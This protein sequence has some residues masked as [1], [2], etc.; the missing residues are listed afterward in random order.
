MLE[1]NH[2]FNMPNILVLNCTEKEY[3]SAMRYKSLILI[4]FSLMLAGCVSPP[5]LQ[6]PISAGSQYPQQ[7]AIML[8]VTGKFANSGKAVLNGF[9]AA[10]YDYLQRSPLNVNIAVVDTAKG[11]INALYKQAVNKGAIFVVGPLT[12]SNVTKLAHENSLE[13]P[14][15]ALNTTDNYQQMHV[16]NLYQ[17]GLFYQDELK[18]VAQRAWQK[19]PGRAMIIAPANSVGRLGVKTLQA[20]WKNYG[21]VINSIVLYSNSSSMEDQI[22]HGLNIDISQSNEKQLHKI[23]RNKL[24][25]NPRR[26][27]D[28]DDVFLIAPAQQAREIRPL[29]AFY[30]AGE[31]PTYST[32]IVYTGAVSQRLDQDLN[33]VIFC[34]APWTLQDPWTLP[35]VLASLNQQVTKTWPSSYKRYS[36][37]YALGIDAFYLMLK[38]NMMA[39]APNQGFMGATGTLFL[40]KY[41]HIYRQLDWAQFRDGVPYEL[42]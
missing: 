6:T 8:P 16:T 11:N 22:K 26:R 3:Y 32:S 10:Y 39:A 25:F 40:D 33:G 15:L 21:G 2:D 17:F 30:F 23:I 29:L 34:D 13:V 20:E 19:H 38:L 14:T 9:L 24:K 7:I 41:N 18:Q 12:K 4:I 42:S 37:F 27:R 28:I 5:Q 1:L 36:R 35:P 31:V